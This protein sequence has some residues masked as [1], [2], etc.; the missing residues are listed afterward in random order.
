MTTARRLP[1]ILTTIQSKHKEIYREGAKSART[2]GN[3]MSLQGK[4]FDERSG[5]TILTAI[6]LPNGRVAL[7][8]LKR[9]GNR[10][11]EGPYNFLGKNKPDPAACLH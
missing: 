11:P 5:S 2:P 7:A 4:D 6:S 3:S 10:N 8:L 1:R 9:P